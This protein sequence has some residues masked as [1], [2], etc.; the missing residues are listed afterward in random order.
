MW[1]DQNAL[2]WQKNVLHYYSITYA[3]KCIYGVSINLKVG[4][5]HAV[6]QCLRCFTNFH[7]NFHSAVLDVSRSSVRITKTIPLYP[8]SMPTMRKGRKVRN[9]ASDF[10]LQ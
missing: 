5:S 7:S 3:G 1:F 8:A 10:L 2:K 9:T 6:S 4:S